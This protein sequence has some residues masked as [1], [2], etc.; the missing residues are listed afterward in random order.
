MRNAFL[1][2]VR[3]SNNDVNLGRLL[4]DNSIARGWQSIYD[5]SAEQKMAFKKAQ[6][7]NQSDRTDD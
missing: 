5:L 2:L 6:S 3:L 1:D 7:E 4:V